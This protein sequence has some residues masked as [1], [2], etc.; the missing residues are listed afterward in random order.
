MNYDSW[1]FKPLLP[2][3]HSQLNGGGGGRYCDLINGQKRDNKINVK[4]GK[5]NPFLAPRL[6]M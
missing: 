2:R 4:R 1:A 6:D 5:K 3:E